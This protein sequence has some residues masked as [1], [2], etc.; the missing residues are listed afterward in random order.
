MFKTDQKVIMER[1][2]SKCDFIH[3]QKTPGD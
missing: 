2:H 3:Q 1:V